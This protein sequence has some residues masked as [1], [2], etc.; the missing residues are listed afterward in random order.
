MENYKSAA[1]KK[2]GLS[3]EEMASVKEYFDEEIR[4]KD[5]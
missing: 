2:L 1:E 3:N 4:G 5:A